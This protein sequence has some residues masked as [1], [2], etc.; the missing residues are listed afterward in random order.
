MRSIRWAV[1]SLSLA[2]LVFGGGILAG[3]LRAQQPA[4]SAPAHPAP[5]YV[6][7]FV[8]IV[9]NNR[10]A[11]VAVIKQYV[12]DMRKQP[13]NQSAEGLVQLNRLNHFFIYEVWQNQEAFQKHEA[14]ASTLQFRNKVAPMLGAPFD[15]RPHFKLE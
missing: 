14:D 13:G 1:L 5:Y 2:A 11:A 10:D 4:A 7:T 12:A 15:E 3:R 9:P 6:I 8:D